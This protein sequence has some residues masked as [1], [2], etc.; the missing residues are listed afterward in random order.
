M[1]VTTP[2]IHGD[3]TDVVTATPE[4]LAAARERWGLD[5]APTA[6]RQ[7]QMEAETLAQAKAAAVGQK[8][9]THVKLYGKEIDY[10]RSL[11]NRPMPKEWKQGIRRY[12]PKTDQTA[13]LDIYW[14]Q[15]PGE[16]DKLRAVIYEMVPA[17]DIP[18]G[19]RLMLEDTPWWEL[20]AERKVGR[21]RMVSAFQWEMYRR[22]RVWARPFWCIQGDN[23]GTPLVYT[24]LEQDML[25]L[26][27]QPTMPPHLGALSFAP[28]DARVEQALAKRD[29]LYKAQGNIERMRKDN[30]DPAKVAAEY[31]SMKR[32]FRKQF[33]DWWGE[34]LQE[35]TEFLAWYETKCEADHTLRRASRAEMLAAARMEEEFVE[36]GRMPIVKPWEND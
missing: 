8:R 27:G 1:S 19:M 6:A 32:E 24:E 11:I 7:K 20:P 25:R 15:P 29:R 30:A 16:P 2:A 35:Q 13:Y 17:K 9:A 22:E 28:Y 23:G 31:E 33:Y 34:Q 21:Q 4:E 14:K 26:K 3:T 36:H 12:S 5:A 18:S 10:V